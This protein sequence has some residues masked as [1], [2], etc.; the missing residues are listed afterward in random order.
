MRGLVELRGEPFP[1]AGGCPRRLAVRVA[2]DEDGL[3]VPEPVE[4]I[5]RIRACDHVTAA[6]DAVDVE[7][8]TSASTASSAGRLPC[9]SQSAATR[10]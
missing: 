4:T 1:R 7:R 9:T 3:D 8:A 2:A 10:I 6:D 5:L